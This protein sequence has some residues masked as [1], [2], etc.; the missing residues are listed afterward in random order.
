MR[1]ISERTQ[2]ALTVM[3]LL[4]IFAP[5]SFQLSR[6]DYSFFGSLRSPFWHLDMWFQNG[7]LVTDIRMSDPFMEFFIWG[8]QLIFVYC[9]YRHT[10]GLLSRR[11]TILCG[12][13]SHS[14]LLSMFFLSLLFLLIPGSSGTVLGPV[15]LVLLIGVLT[16]YFE[17]KEPPTKP[18]D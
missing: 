10:Q 12:I 4:G 7:I 3:A 11:K 13:L 2:Y 17:G 18:W 1:G 16:S 5:T 14:V 15:P 6:S 8:F 9:T